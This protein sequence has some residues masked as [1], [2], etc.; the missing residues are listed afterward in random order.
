[1]RYL[2]CN[3]MGDEMDA[4]TITLLARLRHY[5]DE[6]NGNDAAALISRLHRALET[7]ATAPVDISADYLQR[8]AITA[9]AKVPA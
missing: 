7:I 3:R 8:I 9:L 2:R 5:P 6:S 1:M 4:A